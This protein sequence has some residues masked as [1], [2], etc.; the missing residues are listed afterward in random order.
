MQNEHLKSYL[1]SVREQ[2]E[3]LFVNQYGEPYT[4]VK[5]R[6]HLETLNLNHTRFRNW[7]CRSYYELEGKVPNSEN[8][9]N[10]LNILKANAEFDGNSKELHLRVA[11]DTTIKNGTDS[12]D[13]NDNVL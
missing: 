6:E 13:N 12:N 2:C 3:E 4:A 9:T 5:I 8:I 11:Y 10:T 7:I 1:A